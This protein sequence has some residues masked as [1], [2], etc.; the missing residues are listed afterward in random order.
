MSADKNMIRAIHMKTGNLY[1][2]LCMDAIDC[3]NERDGTKVIVYT[4]DGMV[5]VRERDEFLKK[6]KLAR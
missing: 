3:T 1:D 5:F 4:R 6:F 2:V